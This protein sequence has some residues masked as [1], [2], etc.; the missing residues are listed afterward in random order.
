[1]L[2][3]DVI[4][5]KHFLRYWPF[6]RESTGHWWIP[7]TKASDA[8]LWCFLWSAPE[9]T[10]K[11]YLRR[12]WFETPSLS[13]WRHCNVIH[14]GLDKMPQFYR[15][16]SVKFSRF[17][18]ILFCLKHIEAE[19]K[20]P[21]F[22]KRHF[23]AHFLDWKFLNFKQNFT[24]ICSLWSNWQYGSSGSDNGLAPTRRQAIIWISVG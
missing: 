19:A 23:Q 11:K 6:V 12:R 3:D 2:H 18:T 16:H 7:L 1:M 4:K 24:E 21:A 10:V 8:E 15:R 13:L 22:R 17:E 20:L 5:W 9:Q 14:W